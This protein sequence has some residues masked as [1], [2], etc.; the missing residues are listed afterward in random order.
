M[1]ITSLDQKMT[2]SIYMPGYAPQKQIIQTTISN[3]WNIK[4]N[5][6]DKFFFSADVSGKSTMNNVPLFNGE[7]GKISFS[8]D[9]M[10]NMSGMSMTGKLS[11]AMD[12]SESEF[13]SMT[14][15]VPTPVILMP[16]KNYYQVGEYID[17]MTFDPPEDLDDFPP[18]DIQLLFKRLSTYKGKKVMV[19]TY[20]VQ[21]KVN[22]F[23]FSMS[24]YSLYDAANL[25]CLLKIAKGH[26]TYKCS[27]GMQVTANITIKSNTNVI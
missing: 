3:V 10:G 17:T 5:T 16:K 24:G 21:K 7:M 12:K 13:K 4:K 20:N 2:M 22:A 25:I 14:A 18:I 23:T 15:T 19:V 11:E 1:G 9:S 27:D 8:F 6:S 26:I